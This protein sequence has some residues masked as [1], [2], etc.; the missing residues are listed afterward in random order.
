MSE[1]SA[2][3][4]SDATSVDALAA[5]DTSVTGRAASSFWLVAFAFLIVMGSATLPSP[6]Y[7]LY[8]VRD[9]LSAFTITI[10]YG[11]FAGGTVMSLVAAPVLAARL[12]R[13]GLMLTSVT[14][15]MVSAGLLA[16]WKALPGLIVG[17]CLTGVAVGLAASTAIVYLIELRLSTDPEGIARARTIGTAVSVAGLGLAPLVAG[18]LAQWGSCN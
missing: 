16:G 5:H 15:M 8:R 11:I 7:G 14:T 13:R 9:N 10:V 1:V 17:R 18:L 3:N 2:S 6:L 12:G 4:S